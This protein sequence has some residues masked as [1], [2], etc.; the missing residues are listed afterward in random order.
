MYSFYVNKNPQSTGEHEVHQQGCS[1][2]PA[3]QNC[4]DLG[5]FTSCH[6]AVIEA[7]KY[8][9]NVDGCYYCSRPCHNR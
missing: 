9:S 7:K 4:K 2:M 8:Y 5:L 6:G 1:Y 3:P